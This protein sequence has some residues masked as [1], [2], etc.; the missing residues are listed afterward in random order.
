MLFA[1]KVAF[2]K[3]EDAVLN[4]RLEAV[5]RKNP[6]RKEAVQALFTEAGCSGERF[7]ER[8]VKGS[9]LPNLVC[10]LPGSSDE[11]ILVGAHYDK[12][13]DG[14]GAIDNWSGASLL[15]SLYESHKAYGH[16]YTIWFV[17]F[18]DEEVGL[19]GSKAF[20][21]NMPREELAR[22]KAFVNIDSVGAA[23]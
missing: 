19:V 18:T 13:K 20:V 6:E 16:N 10:V 12:V 14:D 11:I 22:L 7:T 9:K 23:V 1:E 17:A 15:A 8:M 21:K 4:R 3:V 2:D 5:Q